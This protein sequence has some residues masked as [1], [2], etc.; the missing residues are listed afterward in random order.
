MKRD[1]YAWWRDRLSYMFELFDGVRIDHF[2]GIEAFWS[3]PND[4]KSAK[5]GKW[6]NGPGKDFVRMAKSVAG[7]KLLIAE[8]LGDIDDAVKALVDFSGFPGMRVIQFAFDGNADTPHLPFRYGDGCISYTGTHDNN[9]LLGYIWELDKDTRRRLF[10]YCGYFGDDWDEA[11]RAVIRVMYASHSPL[12]IMPIQDVLNYG[13]D[14]RMNTP[15]RSSGNWEY[16]VTKA[17]LDS[18]DRNQFLS[19]AHL[20]GRA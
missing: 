20:Y 17:Q 18:I 10:E 14:T 2:R 13:S 8:D 5:E 3:I 15:G 12:L 9:T 11:Q 16:R 1:G 4:A 6:V 7:E 19:L